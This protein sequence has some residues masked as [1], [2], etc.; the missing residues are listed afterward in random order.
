MDHDLIRT[1]L[2][3]AEANVREAHAVLECWLAQA[4]DAGLIPRQP[5]PGHRFI[6][7]GQGGL[8]EE[9]IPSSAQQVRT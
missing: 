3:Q 1:R 8:V 6:P 9:P 4:E 2:G 7:D 5:R